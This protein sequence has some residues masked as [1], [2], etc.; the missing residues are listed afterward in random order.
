M[1]TNFELMEALQV[2]ER[3]KGVA[4]DTL[5][6]ALANALVS[7]YK[8]MPNAAEEAVVTIDPDSGEMHVY[9]QE[10]DEDGAVRHRRYCGCSQPASPDR[11]PDCDP[12]LH[13]RSATLQLDRAI[14][15]SGSHTEI[16]FSTTLNGGASITR[17]AG[18]LGLDTRKTDEE[19]RI[20]D[21]LVDCCASG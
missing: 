10:L 6:D 3:E 17:G 14:G 1:A 12:R 15:A 9:A 16:V 2:L 8:R 5:L 7:A 19:Q 11:A 21:L 4:M 20:W 18:S 13:G